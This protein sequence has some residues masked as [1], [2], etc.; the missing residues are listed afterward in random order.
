VQESSCPI[1]RFATYTY[2]NWAGVRIIAECVASRSDGQHTLRLVAIDAVQLSS[3][4]HLRGKLLMAR[5][6]LTG[7]QALLNDRRSS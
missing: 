5:D 6:G 4:Q 7:V 1:D 2:F 3:L